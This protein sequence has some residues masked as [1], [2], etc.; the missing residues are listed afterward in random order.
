M[1]LRGDWAAVFVEDVE[2]RKAFGWVQGRV[3][4]VHTL[5]HECDGGRW[6]GGTKAMVKVGCQAGVRQSCSDA[7]CYF[8]TALA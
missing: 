1:I 4:V 7:G 5:P 8:I 2:T 6:A 3:A